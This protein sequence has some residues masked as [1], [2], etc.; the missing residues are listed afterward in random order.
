MQKYPKIIMN[1]E[2]SYLIGP[3]ITECSSIPLG[4]LD[5]SVYRLHRQKTGKHCLLC[6]QAYA[7]TEN[8][9]NRVEKANDLLVA[10]RQKNDGMSWSEKGIGA[11]SVITV[12]NV[13]NRLGSWLRGEKGLL[14]MPEAGAS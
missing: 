13:N 8:I 3:L 14:V 6:F 5:E 2:L 12:L 7:K 4:E 9:S 1:I 11:L 10:K